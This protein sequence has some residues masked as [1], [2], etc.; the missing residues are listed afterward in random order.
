MKASG[1]LDCGDFT[2]KDDHSILDDLSLLLAFD[3]SPDGREAL[4]QA[5]TLASRCGATVHLLAIL[6]AAG[7]M[8]IG[9]AMRRVAD[10]H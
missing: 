4:A 2:R 8:L 1:V 9:E 6:D 10:F 7:S 5:K 3:G